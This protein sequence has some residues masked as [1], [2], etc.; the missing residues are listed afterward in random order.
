MNTESNL[1]VSI[2]IPVFNGGQ[3][4]LRCLESIAETSPPPEE[5]IIV[6]DGESDGSY[7][8]GERVNARTILLD[9]PGGPARARNAG[10]GIARQDI[11]FFV[12]ADV[13]LSK[14]AVGTVKT[15]FGR[16]P[17]IA[18]VI[19]SYDDSPAAPGFLSQFK[20]LFHHYVHQTANTEATTFW[21]GCGAIR[22]SVFLQMDG[23]DEK[24]RKPAIEDIEL[25]YRLTKKGHAIRMVKSLQVKHLKRW[26]LFSL[27]RADIFYRAIPWTDLILR[28]GRLPNDLNLKAS[29]RLSTILTYLMLLGIMGSFITPETGMAA[30]LC[31][32]GLIW[33]NRDVYRFFYNKRGVRFAACAVFWHWFYF[34]YSG[35]AFLLGI[36]FHLLKDFFR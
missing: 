29:G 1:T 27:L 36:F 21:T 23:F 34:F 11:L 20:N 16:N 3:K 25:G 10:A 4:F 28:D 26:N 31:A 33:I 32:G 15:A 18:A 24:Y 30:L 7:K 13:T 8:F 2:V 6:A 12:D 9:S 19:G 14:N 22:R 35:L 5:I 17:D